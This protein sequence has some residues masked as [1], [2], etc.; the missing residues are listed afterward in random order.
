M[1]AVIFDL[2]GTLLDTL[3][4]IAYAANAALA[5]HGH[6]VHPIQAYSQMVGNG[7]PTLMQRAVPQEILPSLTDEDL[8][9]LVSDARAYYGDHP[10]DYTQPYPGIAETLKALHKSGIRLAVLSNKM[11]DLT[12]VL[13]RLHFPTI[14][15]AHVIGSRPGIKLKPDV[16]VLLAMLD[17]MGIAPN[18][19]M[20]VGDSNVDVATAHNAGMKVIGVAWGFRGRRELEESGADHIVEHAADILPLVSAAR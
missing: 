18:D 12:N 13:I 9:K 5:L 1:K 16:T 17:S 4:D 10:T 20:Y 8:Q 15:F 3:A 19:A 2:D 14:P 11:D 7:F 6:P